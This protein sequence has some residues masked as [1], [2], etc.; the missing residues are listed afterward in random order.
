MFRGVLG[1]FI[2]ET[3]WFTRQPLWIPN[4][5]MFSIMLLVIFWFIGGSRGFSQGLV[6]M[7]IAFFFGAGINGVGQSL[8]F[9]RI[10]RITDTYLASPLTLTRYI[11]GVFVNEVLFA[12]LTGIAPLAPLAILMNQMNA[13]IYSIYAGVIILFVG[14]LLGILIGFGVR[15]PT[16]ISA[17]TN[18]INNILIL[19][20]PV[21]YSASYLPSPLREISMAA[22]TA[23]AAELT[24]V[25]AGEIPSLNTMIPVASLISW[26]IVSLILS[27]RVIRLSE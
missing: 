19:L 5:V 12:L 8:G 7:I 22:P 15:R 1:V 16:N 13:L 20:P 9:E 11:T 10:M 24:R 3:R 17:I 27:T 14:T 4:S 6:G 2:L 18:P 26:I 23:A 25:L 21:Y